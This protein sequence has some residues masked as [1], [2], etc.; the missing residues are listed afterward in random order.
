M[1]MCQ[2]MV[3][4]LVLPLHAE[5]TRTIGPGSRNRRTDPSVVAP[6]AGVKTCN[7]C[8]DTKALEAFSLSRRHAD[9]RQPKCPVCCNAR[10]QAARSPQP[11]GPQKGPDNWYG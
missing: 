11:K 2:P 5:L 10:G 1:I 7:E 8:G 4:M 6:M 9:G 3:M